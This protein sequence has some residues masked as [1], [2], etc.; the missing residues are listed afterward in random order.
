MKSWERIG[1][2]LEVDWFWGV[3]PEGDVSDPKEITKSIKSD[4]ER[5]PKG[6]IYQGKTESVI[7][8]YLKSQIAQRE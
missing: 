8:E 5:D 6:N 7:P 1:N 4:H 3:L 2:A